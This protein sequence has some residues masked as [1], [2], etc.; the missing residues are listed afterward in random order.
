[1]STK[2]FDL[3]G[4]NVLITGS[5]RG[6]GLALGT[7][8]A[9]AG[10]RFIVSDVNAAAAEESA[11]NLRKRGLQAVTCNFD[12]TSD[13]AV[14]AAIDKI[15]T[16][17]GPLDILVNNAGINLRGS[18][19][20]M[21]LSTWQKVIDINLT[22]VWRVGKFAAQR[23][24]PRRRGKIINIASLM[25]FGGRPTTGPYTATKTAIAG[26]TRAMTVD[27]AQHNLQINAI[28]PG[29]F[30][31]EMTK[32]LAENPEFD[33]WVKMRTPAKRWGEP[34][35]LVGLA[36]FFASAASD[37]VTGQVVYVDGGWTSNL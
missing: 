27:W 25:T 3:T 9:E 32:P 18:L 31:T 8:L 17:I 5:A 24:I 2:L 28:G 4:K 10:A 20:E 35:E 21:E 22:A 23:M 34:K 11:E 7:G 16:E 29:Y 26:L 13:D 1:M 19:E 37:F 14:K 33:S 30:L 6:L 36:V 12:V 15:E